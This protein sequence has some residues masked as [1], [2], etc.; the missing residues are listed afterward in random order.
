MKKITIAIFTLFLSIS[1]AVADLKEITPNQLEKE[2]SS[3]IVIIDIRRAEEWKST[4]VVPS[5]NKL[6]FFDA[7]G[8][9]DVNK[10]MN[11]FGK[12]VKNKSQKVVLVCRTANRTTA[13]GNF[14]SQQVGMPNVYHLKGGI[15]NWIK[16]NKKVIK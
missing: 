16:Q 5:S 7:R 1:F 10:W 4:G 14:L 3:D 2:I 12:L 8:K 15:V 13:V 9:Y 6:T 11:E